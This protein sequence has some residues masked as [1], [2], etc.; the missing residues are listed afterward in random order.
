MLTWDR[1]ALDFDDILLRTQSFREDQIQPSFSLTAAF[2]LLFISLVINE[3][4][5]SH[6]I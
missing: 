1:L 2:F 4:L 5:S 3:S 6:T